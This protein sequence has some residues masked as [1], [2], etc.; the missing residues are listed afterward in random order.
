MF[1]IWF[2]VRVFGGKSPLALLSYQMLF[3]CFYGQI[4]GVI[5]AGLALLWWSLERKRWLLAGIGAALALI[6][7]QMG[8]PLCAALIA[9]GGY[10]VV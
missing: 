5:V 7:W 3:V 6:K 2:A 4:A 10:V 1:G 9:A 8:L